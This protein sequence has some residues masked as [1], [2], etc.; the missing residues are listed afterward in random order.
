MKQ[1]ITTSHATER[2]SESDSCSDEETGSNA[3][4]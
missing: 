2:D 4:V 1:T 3:Y